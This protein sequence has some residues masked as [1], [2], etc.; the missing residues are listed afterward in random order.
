[1]AKDPHSTLRQAVIIGVSVAWLV[2]F[3]ASLLITEYQT[4]PWLNG[5]ATAIV[6]WATGREV[7]HR[8]GG[9]DV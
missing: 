6:A 3:T 8:N 9:G 5:M 7:L 1:M 4:S 2:S